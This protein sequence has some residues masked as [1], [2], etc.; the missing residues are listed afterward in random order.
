MHG[1]GGGV[2]DQ[3]GNPS[4]NSSANIQSLEFVLSLQEK[5]IIPEE[6]TSALVSQLF[7]QNEAAMAINGPW[8]LGEIN[9]DID[10]SVYPLP[11]ISSTNERAKLARLSAH[12]LAHRR[13]V[14]CAPS[15]C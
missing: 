14:Q 1:F 3:E 11:V 4:L 10:F 5:G 6:P 9:P 2:F 15:A 13:A 12:R 7:N 8:F